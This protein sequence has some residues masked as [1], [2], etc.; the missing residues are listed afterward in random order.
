MWRNVKKK[1]KN[2]KPTERKEHREKNSNK[3]AFKFANSIIYQ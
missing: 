1:P 2:F 3:N